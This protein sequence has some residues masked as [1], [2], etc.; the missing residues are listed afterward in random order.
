MSTD[1]IRNEC[2]INLKWAEK[3]PGLFVH[4]IRRFQEN[5][6]VTEWAITTDLSRAGFMT[7]VAVHRS[8]A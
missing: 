5:H 6:P 4:T 2:E 7:L 1:R 3:N 8:A